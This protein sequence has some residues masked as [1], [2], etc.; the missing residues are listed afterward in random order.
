MTGEP[1]SLAVGNGAPS[2]GHI[3]FSALGSFRFADGLGYPDSYRA[4]IS[5]YGWA[6]TFGLWLIYPPVRPGYADGRQRA[7]NLTERFLAS[8]LDGQAEEFD[9]MVEPDGTWETATSLRVLG[10]SENGDALLWDTSARRADGEFPVWE[11]RGCD[12]LHLLGATLTD[13]LPRMRERAYALAR[14][15]TRV[16]IE[17]LTA[18]RL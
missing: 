4:F 9:W 6:R 7:E 12:S 13:A 14:E 15:G 1:L 8:Y 3:D 16:D 10:W 17:P 18:T 11:S 2:N 5:E